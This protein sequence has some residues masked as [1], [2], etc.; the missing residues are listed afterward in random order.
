MKMLLPQL[1]PLTQ[2]GSEIHDGNFVSHQPK[3]IS[4]LREEL[5]HHHN[6]QGQ[7]E[8]VEHLCETIYLVFEVELTQ[9]HE[10]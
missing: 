4:L 2:F 9:F 3:T 10:L 7:R 6:L 8:F 5:F 1:P